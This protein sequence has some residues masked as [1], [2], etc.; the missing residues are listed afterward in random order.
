MQG[1]CCDARPSHAGVVIQ[2]LL[3]HIGDAG[4]SYSD[5]VM[6]GLS[7]ADVVMQDR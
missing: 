6:Q 7:N 1:R 4:P 2:G 5:V 3:M